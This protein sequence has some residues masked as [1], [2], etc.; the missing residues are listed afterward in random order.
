MWGLDLGSLVGRGKR[1]DVHAY[2]DG[3]VLKL[4]VDGTDSGEAAGEAEATKVVHDLGLPAPACF[5]TVTVGA[6]PG[7]VFERVDGP[8]MLAD[9]LARPWRTL[10][11][12]RQM[13]ELH[14]VIHGAVI[15]DRYPSQR[16]AVRRKILAA[17]RLDEN[18][19]DAA[20]KAL[21]ALPDGDR[22]CHGDFHPGNVILG[23]RGPVVIDWQDAKRGN[24]AA[25]IARTVLLARHAP[26][27]FPPGPHRVVLTLLTRLLVTGYLRYYSRLRPLRLSDVRAWLPV[28]AAARLREGLEVEETS[29]LRLAGLLAGRDPICRTE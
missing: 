13:A 6:R 23:P 4:F 2:G 16:E 3:R 21:A 1:A 26:L 27:H 5:G 17:G 19:R 8:T 20:L 9:F 7:I 15:S 28:L 29:L 24:P 14:A 18:L 25:D 11:V 10:A 12:A 22:V